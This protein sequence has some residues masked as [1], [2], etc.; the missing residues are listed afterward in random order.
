MSSRA[1]PGQVQTVRGAVAPGDLG[2]TLPHEHT[3]CSL[4]WIENRWDYWELIGDEP[5]I[6]E[7]LGA[8]KALGGGAV[9][10]VTPVGIGRD[11]ERLTRLSQATGLHI[12]AG[13]GWYRQAYYPAEARIDRRSIDDLADEIVQE[14]VDGPVR[15]GIIGEIGTDKPWVTAQEERVFRAAARAALRTGASVTTHAVQS[16]VGLAQLDILE[17]EGL[18]PA[19][20]VIGHCDSHPRIEHWREIVRR[21]AHVEADFLG[22][23]FT[24]LE[25]AGEPKVIELIATLLNEG[26]EQ[27]ILL[28]QDVC[29]DSQLASYGGNG[30]TYLQRS[31]LPRLIAAG[32]DAATINTITVENPS[33]LLTLR[34]PA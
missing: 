32:V 23:S 9:V 20:V 19:R 14:F 10:D 6:N 26:F 4:W 34:A 25:R 15:P 8:Y 22:M 18:D 29:H 17:D 21:G 7:E 1:V 30:Y 13:S 16:D 2:F 33:R 5:R 28:S 24:P 27:Q 11:L 31:F 3:K 12:V